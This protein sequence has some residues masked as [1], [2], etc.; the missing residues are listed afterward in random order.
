MRTLTIALVIGLVLA[1]LTAAAV[2]A[3]SDSG[4]VTFTVQ[5]SQ[6]LTVSSLSLGTVT[7]GVNNKGNKNPVDVSSNTAWEVTAQADDDFSDG[8]SKT[9]TAD[10]LSLS[11]QA[12]STSTAKQIA[13]GS[14]GTTQTPDVATVLTV[15]WSLDAGS[16]TAFSGSI[17]YTLSPQ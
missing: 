11:G 10:N 9:L 6:Q 8:G 3:T 5:P 7:A 12:M 4:S 2:A 1:G 17:T 16:G 14:A 15:P 13:T